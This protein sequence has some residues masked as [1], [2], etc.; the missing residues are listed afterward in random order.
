MSL[1]HL[2]PHLAAGLPRLA[3]VCLCLAAAAGDLRTFRIPNRMNAAILALWPLAWAAGD[4][5]PPLASSAWALAAVAAL[6]GL[7]WRLGHAYPA[8]RFGGGD[9]K[10]MSALAPWAGLGGLPALLL[11]TALLG[12]VET[13]LLVVLRAALPEGSSAR[14]WNWLGPSLASSGIPYGVAIAGGGILV[15]LDCTGG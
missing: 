4:V 1:A 13:V 14:A 3:A 7:Q 11:A 8:M 10:M 15:L 12:G 9:W 6:L 5:L 2:L